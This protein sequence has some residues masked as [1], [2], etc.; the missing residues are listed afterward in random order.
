MIIYHL[1]SIH[2]LGMNY[3]MNVICKALDL[4]YI[5]WTKIVKIY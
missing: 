1:N 3:K 2:P 5:K 4:F